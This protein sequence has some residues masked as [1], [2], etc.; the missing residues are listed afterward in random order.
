M[1]GGSGDRHR[2]TSWESSPAT[3]SRR[4]PSI[5][6]RSRKKF[7]PQTSPSKAG[8]RLEG[9]NTVY[10]SIST[11]QPQQ[12]TFRGTWNVRSQKNNR[13]SVMSSPVFDMWPRTRGDGCVIRL[14][15]ALVTHTHTHTPPHT[16]ESICVTGHLEQRVRARA[17]AVN[18]WNGRKRRA[19]N[20]LCELEGRLRFLVGLASRLRRRLEIC[21]FEA[22]A[23]GPFPAAHVRRRCRT[24]R[25]RQPF[26]VQQRGLF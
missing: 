18:Q 20:Q 21:F 2:S 17:A 10:P 1:R 25:A 23:F 5:Q 14:S 15:S 6:P 4:G 19:P 13:N 7:E 12:D 24:N 8:S 26:V 22:P 3:R 9:Q 11:T 16:K